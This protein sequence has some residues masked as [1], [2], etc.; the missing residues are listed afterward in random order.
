M[1]LP[2]LFEGR[3]KPSHLH[4][5]GSSSS[6]NILP[7]GSNEDDETA[8]QTDSVSSYGPINNFRRNTGFAFC[9]YRSRFGHLR[10][11]YI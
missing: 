2:S 4:R 11:G 1:S 8:S 9:F 6:T 7:F 10:A 3:T 5:L